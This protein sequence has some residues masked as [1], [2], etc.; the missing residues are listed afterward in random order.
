MKLLDRLFLRTR[1][2]SYNMLIQA[3]K[4]MVLITDEKRL[5]KLIV[6]VVKRYMALKSVSI[7]KYDSISNNFVLICRRGDNTH[8]AGY[9]MEVNNPLV[10][11]LKEYKTVLL[12]RALK[13]LDSFLGLKEEL[14]R[15]DCEICVPSFWKDNLLGYLILGKK[16][17]NRPFTKKEVN[18]L[19][20]LSNS[21]SIALEN[22][23]NFSELEKARKREKESYFQM[24]LALAR[25]ADEKDP[26][27]RGHMD[28]VTKY[29][30][31]VA[32]ELLETNSIKIDMEELEIALML[33]DIGKIGVP[34]A[35]LHKNGSLTPEEWVIMKQHCEIGARIVE[36][37]ER[38][39]NVGNIIKHHQERYDG[40]GYPYGLKGEDI[41]L[42]SRIIAV[43]DAFHAMTSDRP[44][45]KALPED[46][47]LNELRNCAG[48]QFDPIVVNAF[49]KAWEK[50]KIKRHA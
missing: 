26:Y 16:R 48:T 50:G 11:W 29:G 18:L 13:G 20:M 32:E 9:K 1:Y 27:T 2:S 31:A 8:L 30:L 40:T 7:F 5:L 21:V 6:Y 23:K 34:D 46:A 37:I 44:Y 15:L 12:R 38:L 47:A 4:G 35:L 28:E 41:P 42:E 49:L 3:S 36:P 43:V 10:T 17:S 24:V 33:H 22:A 14:T 45:R 39:K 19:S 25:T